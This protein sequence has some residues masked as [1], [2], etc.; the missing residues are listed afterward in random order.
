MK[1]DD[2]IR[3]RIIKDPQFRAQLLAE[4]TRVV[5]PPGRANVRVLE[6]SAQVLHLVIPTDPVVF[7]AT[8]DV[9]QQV[10]AKA[11]TDEVFHACLCRDPRSTLADEL[12]VELP[13]D[14]RVVVVH[15][16][17]HVV[18]VV[19]PPNLA[20]GMMAAPTPTSESPS[21]SSWGG[22]VT[23]DASPC[24]LEGNGFCTATRGC[25]SLAGGGPCNPKPIEIDKNTSND[26]VIK[27]PRVR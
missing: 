25:N 5:S 16:N 20:A 17:E 12:G 3:E 26:T 19:C 21:S 24:T 2:R 6:D 1:I 8:A 14:L 10:I 11:Q 7:D 9:A 27:T 18:H 13:D 23:T 15:D 22:E 4:P